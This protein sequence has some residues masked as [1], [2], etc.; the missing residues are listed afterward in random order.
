LIVPW[1]DNDAVDEGRFVAEIMA[2]GGSG[3]EGVYT[4]GTTGEFYAQDDATFETI[5]A[6]ACRQAHAADLLAQIGCTALSTRTCRQRIRVAQRHGADAVQV[7]IPFWLELK[8]DELLSFFDGITAEAGD[9]PLVLYDTARAKRRM[10]PEWIG[11]LAARYPTL[12][13]VKNTAASP[14]E[15]RSWLERAP[16]ISVFG[17]E[18]DLIERM[19]VG[20]RGTYSAIAGLNAARVVELYRFCAAGDWFAA[21]PIQNELRRY[22]TEAILP[23]VQQDGLSDSAVDRVQRLLGGGDVG[24]RC[25]GPYLSATP[26][27]LQK[28]EQWCRENLPHLLP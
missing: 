19:Q 8:D 5:T 6:I 12:I 13:G 3:V 15:I 7:A 11:R 23:L 21:A 24:L 28:V 26:E 18:H 14:D 27:Q 9:T 17:A 25:Q 2:Y 16:D 4:G 20:G 10:T 22:E 1:T